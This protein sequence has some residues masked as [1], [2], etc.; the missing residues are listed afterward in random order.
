MPSPTDPREA[1]FTALRLPAVPL[2]PRPGFADELRRRLVAELA[3]AP[4]TTTRP[5]DPQE[6]P[7]ST[8]TTSTTTAPTLIP[9]LAVQG[10]AAAI[11]WYVDV[12]GAVEVMRYLGDDGRVGHAE[13]VIGPAQVYLSD[14]FPELGVEH[15]AGATN[16][17]ALHLEVA[18]VDR[19][20]ERAVAAGAAGLRPPADQEHGNRNATVRDPFG[21]R[22]M[23]SQPIDADRAAE[24][25]ASPDP[26]EVGGSSWTITGRQ[27]VEPGYLVLHTADL[28][29]ARAFYGE[30]FDWQI[31]DGGAGGGHVANTRFPL[32]IAPPADDAAERLA[33]PASTTIYFRVDDLDTYATRVTELGGQVLDRHQYPSGGDVECVDDQ[34]YR[35]DL[36]KPAPGY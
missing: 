34:G 20:Y 3:P 7:V 19:T 29:R 4:T 28:A 9:Y 15:P 23:I 27:P 2:A 25:A 16:S 36:W 17:V 18:D 6:A 14:D 11:D 13:L 31:E 12:L 21:H 24:A 32:G 33:G 1:P 5:P 35:F 30:L 10:A 22:W 8:T 26:D